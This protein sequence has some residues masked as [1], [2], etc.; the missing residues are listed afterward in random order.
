MNVSF[1]HN[2][3][4]ILKAQITVVECTCGCINSNI[5]SI[6]KTLVISSHIEVF[7]AFLAVN[8]NVCKRD[9]HLFLILM[10]FITKTFFGSAVLFVV[11]SS[12][13]SE[14]V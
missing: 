5:Q 14:K 3:T 7:T 4:N 10:F 9:K 2:T 12:S 6:P 8:N 11:R 13:F 1:A